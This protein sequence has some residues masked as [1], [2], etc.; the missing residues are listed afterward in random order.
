[1]D[2][3]GTIRV[4]R[5]EIQKWTQR[6]RQKTDLHIRQGIDAG[7]LEVADRPGPGC[8]TTYQSTIPGVR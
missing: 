8:S 6:P 3:G 1:M 7:L 2:A 4:A 5:K